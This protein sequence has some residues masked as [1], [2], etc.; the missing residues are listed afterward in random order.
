MLTNEFIYVVCSICVRCNSKRQPSLTT[1]LLNGE[2][3]RR[4]GDV[5]NCVAIWFSRKRFTKSHPSFS[6]SP[7][8]VANAETSNFWGRIIQRHFT[9]AFEF[10]IVS[11]EWKTNNT[12][13]VG[14]GKSFK[15]FSLIQWLPA[16][17]Y[18]QTSTFKSPW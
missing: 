2:M 15:C 8:T 10:S 13:M 9:E 3:L 4:K 12:V 11:N 17:S 5:L 6:L 16:N 18:L 14:H 1:K 7:N